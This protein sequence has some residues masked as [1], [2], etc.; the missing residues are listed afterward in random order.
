MQELLSLIG[1]TALIASKKYK[2]IFYKCEFMNLTET[3]K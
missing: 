2:N 3:V 1:N